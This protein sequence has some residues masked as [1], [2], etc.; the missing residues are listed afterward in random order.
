MN[1]LYINNA[2]TSIRI[3]SIINI[4]LQIFIIA[5]ILKNIK[6]VKKVNLLFPALLVVGFFIGQLALSTSDIYATSFKENLYSSNLYTLNGYLYIFIY[7]IAYRFIKDKKHFVDRVYKMIEYVL[8]FNAIFVVIGLIF[9]LNYFKSY[10]YTGRFGYDGLFFTRAYLSYL[11]MFIIVLQYKKFIVTKQYGKLAFFVILALILGKKSMYLFLIFMV[12]LHIFYISKS[13]ILKTVFGLGIA[14][15]VIFGKSILVL[16]VKRMPFWNRVY[17][18]SGLLSVI[19]SYRNNTVERLS[20]FITEEWNILNYIF[21]GVDFSNYHTEMELVD[22]FS[23]FGIFGLGLYI[24]FFKKIILKNL[25]LLDKLL[26]LMIFL[27]SSIS[28]NLLLS[29]NVMIFLFLL[30][31][32]IKLKNT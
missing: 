27:T 15:I 30:T 1:I 18:E 23:F 26:M 7:I 28:S 16:V 6:H 19:F 10:P 2:Q 31:E 29:V 25:G 21:G 12:L 17:E 22:V 32:H 20:T 14:S 13:K 9:D 3:S 4:L 8:V 5:V 11:Y 24:L